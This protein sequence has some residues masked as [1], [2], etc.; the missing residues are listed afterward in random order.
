M[1]N[2]VFIYIYE[3]F[4]HGTIIYNPFLEV[5]HAC[6]LAVSGK[7]HT[8]PPEWALLERAPEDPLIDPYVHPS[9]NAVHFLPSRW[10]GTATVP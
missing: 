2:Y 9:Q 8:D 10:S 3:R 7:L 4:F 1:Y 5:I 6:F